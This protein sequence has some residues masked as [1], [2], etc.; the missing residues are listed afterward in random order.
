MDGD[1]SLVERREQQYLVLWI[2]VVSASR[3]RAKTPAAR[4]RSKL[5]H[6]SEKGSDPFLS[7]SEG[8]NAA[9]QCDGL[10]VDIR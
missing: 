2:S 10:T 8:G 1:Y 5:G 7:G 6:F 4:E 3:D 9:C